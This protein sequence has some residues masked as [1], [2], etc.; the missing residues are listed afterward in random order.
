MTGSLNRPDL[1]YP[2]N[3]NGELLWERFGRK[4]P[5][6]WK[7][8]GRKQKPTNEEVLKITVDLLHVNLNNIILWEII[9]FP[10][11]EIYL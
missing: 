11:E 4:W 5:L 9:I 8:P 10:K 1:C 6:W 3:Q 7:G 2:A